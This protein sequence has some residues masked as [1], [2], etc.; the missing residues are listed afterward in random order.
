[1]K[2]I[3]SKKPHF[4]QSADHHLSLMN[5]SMK[6]FALLCS[7]LQGRIRCILEMILGVKTRHSVQKQNA[8]MNF[9]RYHA[10]SFSAFQHISSSN[11]AGFH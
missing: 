9:K 7:L 4:Y 1:M 8:A 10:I 6:V 3:F 11:N 2:P 5:C